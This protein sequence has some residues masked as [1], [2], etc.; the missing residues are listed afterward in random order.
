M[1]ELNTFEIDMISGSGRA[2]WLA[3]ADA[4]IDFLEGVY[5]GYSAAQ[6]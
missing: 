1:T 6:S 3:L 5:A 4:A 2:G